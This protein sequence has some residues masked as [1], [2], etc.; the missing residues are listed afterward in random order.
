MDC[1]MV[2]FGFGLDWI[3]TEVLWCGAAREKVQLL[4]QQ[5]K[6]N[7]NVHDVSSDLL[8][9]FVIDVVVVCHH[10]PV[11]KLAILGKIRGQM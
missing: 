6:F 9:F 5:A 3:F 11:S 2:G 1:I 10:A 8:S 7:E 4:V